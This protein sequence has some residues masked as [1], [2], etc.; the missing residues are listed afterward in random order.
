MELIDLMVKKHLKLSWMLE[1]VEFRLHFES[2][3]QILQ[4]LALEGDDFVNVAK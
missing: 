2:F 3:V 4:K 1:L